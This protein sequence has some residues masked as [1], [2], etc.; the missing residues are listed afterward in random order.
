[1]EFFKTREIINFLHFLLTI[2]Q[3]SQSFQGQLLFR[4]VVIISNLQIFHLQM[5]YC[6]RRHS[7]VMQNKK[8]LVHFIIALSE[9]ELNVSKNLFHN[10]YCDAMNE[11]GICR[12]NVTD[13]E[14]FY[15]NVPSRKFY[16]IKRRLSSPLATMS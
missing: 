11:I 10:S 4:H 2:S 3:A 6:V 14:E 1:M 13:C 7:N 12:G 8:G 9:L 16:W 5:K 15:R